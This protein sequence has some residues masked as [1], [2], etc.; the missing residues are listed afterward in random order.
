MQ[1]VERREKAYS[2]WYSQAVSHPNTNQAQPC[3]VSEIRHVQG[4]V[5]IMNMLCEKCESYRLWNHAVPL[6][7]QI[8]GL[9]GVCVAG[10]FSFLM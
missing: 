7:N 4:G 1:V 8:I 3:L 5:S 10:T 9:R 2:T 6:Y